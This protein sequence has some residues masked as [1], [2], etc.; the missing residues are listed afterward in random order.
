MVADCVRAHGLQSVLADAL[1]GR[2]N[3]LCTLAG[4]HAG[5]HL[6]L[7]AHADTRTP[8]TSEPLLATGGDAFSDDVVGVGAL[9]KAGLAAM[10]TALTALHDANALE[11]GAVTL[12]VLVDREGEGLGVEDLVRSPLRADAAIVAEPTGNRLCIGH[13]GVEF[14]EVI[15]E[16]ADPGPRAHRTAEALDALTAAVRFVQ[17]LNETLVPSFSQNAHPR[18][19]PPS[20][21]VRGIH[22]DHPLYGSSRCIV[23]VERSLVPD[24][25]FATVCDELADLIRRVEAGVPGLETRLRRV[26]GTRATLDHVPLLTDDRAAV[27]KAVAEARRLVQGDAGKPEVFPNWSD[28]GMLSLYGGVPA[29]LLGPGEPADAQRRVDRVSADAV[30]EAAELFIEAALAFCGGVA[31]G[32]ASLV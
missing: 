8:D 29:V 17:R 10:T 1:V 19:G 21:T 4:R 12:V 7:C 2:P 22:G 6:M 3:L 14:L 11:H 28:A 25:T 16:A 32:Q 15:F 5:P 24:E 31:R 30:A 9:S 26:A 13:P 23:T 20:L 27:V 18:L